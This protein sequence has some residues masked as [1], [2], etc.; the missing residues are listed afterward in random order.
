MAYRL[1]ASMRLEVAPAVF[2]A[3]RVAAAALGGLGP[4][5]AFACAGSVHV[6]ACCCP[7]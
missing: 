3:A 4:R 7:G 5:D 6:A 1:A 2:L